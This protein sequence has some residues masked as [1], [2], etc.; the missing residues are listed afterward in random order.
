[1]ACKSHEVCK[2][3][4]TALDITRSDNNIPVGFVLPTLVALR[5]KFVVLPPQLYC[6]PLKC[7][8]L[9]GLQGRFGAVI[10]DKKLITSTVLTPRFKLHWVADTE[11]QRAARQVHEVLRVSASMIEGRADEQRTQNT[12]VHGNED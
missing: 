3:L 6:E 9:A 5:R 12:A 11:E 7:A 1:M 2:P 8:V 10:G 4:A